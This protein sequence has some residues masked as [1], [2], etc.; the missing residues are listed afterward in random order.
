MIAPQLKE[1]PME[2]EHARQKGKQFLRM[3]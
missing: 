1:Q 3:K 2:L